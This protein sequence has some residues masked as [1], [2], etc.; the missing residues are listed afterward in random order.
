MSAPTFEE[1]LYD[2]KVPLIDAFNPDE[3]MTPKEVADLF[4]VKSRT[5]NRWLEGNL[6]FSKVRS[7]KTPGGHHRFYRPDVLNV[8]EIHDNQQPGN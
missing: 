1:K 7:F 2:E 8:L 4:K 3:W 6:Q 5:V